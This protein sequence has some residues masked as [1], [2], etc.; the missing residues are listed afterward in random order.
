MLRMLA[1]IYYRH[2][3]QLSAVLKENNSDATAFWL[4]VSDGPRSLTEI[5]WLFRF[6][7]NLEGLLW[8][9][10]FLMK[11]KKSCALKT[12]FLWAFLNACFSFPLIIL[13]IN[14]WLSPVIVLQCGCV[15]NTVDYP[16]FLSFH[17]CIYSD[18]SFKIF[19]RSILGQ[20][21]TTCIK[22]INA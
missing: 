21:K 8:N 11:Q 18:L 15:L 7:F 9:N 20:Y 10:I 2:S 6:D 4:L 14:L 16:S 19:S 1:K 3:F 17:Y 12:R 5:N 22:I 13:R